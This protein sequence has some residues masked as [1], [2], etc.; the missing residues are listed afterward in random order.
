M[1]KRLDPCYKRLSDSTFGDTRFEL[2]YDKTW[3]TSTDEGKEWAETKIRAHEESCDLAGACLFIVV[4]RAWTLWHV[5]ADPAVPALLSLV[6]GWKLW[7][8]C[9]HLADSIQLTQGD[10][11]L[12]GMWT[13]LNS[14]RDALKSV[15]WTIQ[16]SGDTLVLPYCAA[17]A[18]LTMSEKV[19]SPTT[20][21]LSY[22]VPFPPEVE[23]EKEHFVSDRFATGHRKGFKEHGN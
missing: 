21:L 22:F 12:K 6:S 4:G 2:C 23:P 20:G 19:G 18:V 1:S 3:A 15:K 5:D 9:E 10:S 14:G 13:L 17:H 16:K 7:F 11:S 8:I